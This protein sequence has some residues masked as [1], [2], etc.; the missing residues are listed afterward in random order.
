M[1]TTPA[2]KAIRESAER[3]VLMSIPE[4]RRE[5]AIFSFDGFEVVGVGAL[6][7]TLGDDHIL[8]EMNSWSGSHI[9]HCKAQ[10]LIP[11]MAEK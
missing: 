1:L 8:T 10:K 6:F 7:R 4:K 11:Y 9:F 2:T 5:T 3:M